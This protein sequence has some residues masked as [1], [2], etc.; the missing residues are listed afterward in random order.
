MQV[1]EQ[2][3]WWGIGLGGLV[4]VLWFLGDVIL[5]FVAGAAV[6]YFLD[7]VA[8]RLERL[9]LSRVM[10]TVVITLVAILV[11]LI[12]VLILVPLVITQLSDLV[13]QAPAYSAQ[14]QTFLQDRVP[15]LM[16]ADSAIR[17][18][19]NDIALALK[20]RSGQ[21]ATTLLTS[22][23]TVIDAVIFM[24]VVPVVAFYLLLDWDRMIAIVNS[25][26]P[27][28]HA[29]TIRELAREVDKV[30]AGFVRGQISVAAIQ[31]TFYAISLM[32]V[33]LQ[34]G[35][36]VGLTAGMV[37]F[38]PYVGATVGGVA[39]IGLALFQFWNEPWW[40]GVVAGIFV[41]GQ[42]IEGN[43]LTPKLVGGS[44][45]LHP[46]WLMFAL[47]VFGT[48]FGFVGLLV[49]VPMAATIGVFS[50]FGIRQYLGGRLYR[51]AGTDLVDG[52]EQD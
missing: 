16:E 48:L 43:F 41:A 28:D 31:G 22:A 47:S 20:A 50:R 42:V 27:L 26:L 12:G 33:G 13:A 9:G 14:I 7:P 30:L 8:D 52:G 46:V 15:G 36:V 17:Q 1:K 10:A 37:S 23:F 11:F 51:G 24:V 3:R 4:L 38:I 18:T 34:F 32:L 40:I 2:M 45:G 21:I 6:A 29:A 19:L 25:W 49:A 5:P 39:A 44:V 35:L